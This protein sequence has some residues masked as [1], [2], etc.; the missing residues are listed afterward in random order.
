M[1]THRLHQPRLFAFLTL[2]LLNF[3]ESVKHSHIC[4]GTKRCLSWCSGKQIIQWMCNQY[5][6]KNSKAMCSVMKPQKRFYCESFLW[7]C[8]LRDF[9]FLNFHLKCRLPVLTWVVPRV[10]RDLSRHSGTPPKI[11]LV[12]GPF[13]HPWPC[14]LLWCL[15]DASVGCR[16]LHWAPSR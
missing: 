7:R 13:Q 4:H 14:L 16:A 15:V 10:S 1:F 3:Q 11:L 6:I 5:L 9:F 8:L 12:C 2:S